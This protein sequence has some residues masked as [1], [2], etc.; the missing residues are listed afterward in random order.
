LP[1]LDLS[2]TPAAE[3]EAAVHRAAE[4]ESDRPFDLTRG[5]LMRALLIRESRDRHLL[6]L[7]VHHIVFDGFSTAV[8]LRDLSALYQ[9][10][11]SGRPADL[12]VLPVQ[13]VDYA[14]WQQEQLQGPGMRAR[15]DRW[16]SRLADASRV[17]DLPT[18]RPRPAVQSNRGEMIPV[19]L[20][21]A[22]AAEIRNLAGRE[23]ATLFMVLLAGYAS[24]LSR[25]T[26]QEDLNVG[27]FVANRPRAA[28]EGL[29][30][31]F[32]N[33]LVLR[34]DLAGDPSFRELLARVRETSLDAFE[35][36]EVP[37]ESLLDELEIGR[38]LSRN[39]LFQV[40]FGLQNF[41]M[42]TIETPGLR[43]RPVTL[44]QHSRTNAELAFWLA[45]EGGTLAGLLQLSTDL[46]DASTVLRMFGHLE[47]LLA[48][49][50]ADP[51]LRLSELPLMSAEE[52][53]QILVEW[54]RPGER[55]PAP[56]ALVHERFERWAAVRPDAV[57]LETADRSEVLTYAELNRRGNRLA[58]RLRRLGVG[59]DSIVGI[60]AERCV[61]HIVSILGVLKAGGAYMPL[62]PSLPEERLGAQIRS[63]GVSVILPLDSEPA[64]M[65]LSPDDD[66]D[67]QP[68]AVPE[69]LAYTFFTS[70]STGA[71][72]G[73]LIP[74][75][76]LANFAETA[77]RLY[78]IG[79]EDRVLQFSSLVFDI[80]VEE[81]FA[82]WAAG[83]TLV[84]RDEEMISSPARFLRACGELDVQMLDLPT[85]YWHELGIEL[86]KGEV[87][88]PACVRTVI[89]AGERALQERLAGWP[90]GVRLLNS[91]G[92][93]E[94]CPASSV[95][96][97]SETVAGASTN[98]LSIGRPMRGARLYVADFDHRPV[99]VGVAGELLIA[100]A[101][102]GR[103][104]AGQPDLTAERFIPDPFASVPGERAYRTGD[105][106]RWLRDGNLKFLGR[107]DHQ[108]KIRGFRIEPG[109]IAAVLCRYP[110]VREAVVVPRESVAAGTAVLQLV[111][112]A[113]AEPGIGVADLRKHV[114]SALPAYMVPADFVLLDALP[115][116]ATGKLDRRALPAPG[117]VGD[118]NYAAPETATEELLAGIWADLLGRERVGVFDDFF[119]LGGHSL[120]AP[121][122]LARIEE[123]FQ[124]E[125]PLRTLFEAPTVAQLATRIEEELLAQIEELSDEE[126]QSLMETL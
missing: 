105:R 28:L 18:D 87:G 53:S 99:P 44:T 33:T 83:S 114:K 75:G 76:A 51:G 68:L 92:P 72:K 1:L 110:G 41:A 69:S 122:V 107:V 94:A 64:G 121:Q 54:N 62:D 11:V 82:S 97:A 49:G 91:Y 96:D 34:V 101:G 48:A 79:S 26:G 5:P 67:P 123:T 77:R 120:L 113:A 109:E 9:A 74:H 32:V 71:P 42:P 52:T 10:E 24:L 37:F 2:A 90:R 84:L 118:D 21:P 117:A 38:D 55:E 17:L 39:P 59:L 20:P 14:A 29:I 111:A 86:A 80:S 40:L 3:R 23:G 95:F 65:P 106:V 108:V 35:N 8:L 57:A 6:A 81:I 89:F 19:A 58:H 46:F 112:Y 115:L 16:K 56:D 66:L 22:G 63:S 98:G 60:R 61:E 4:S 78:G 31:F 116:T 12:P 119:D 25:Y 100:G 13:Y 47:R 93:T 15:L 125:L 103:G 7:T 50:A 104:Y 36:Q 102:V 27:T 124:V 30:G 70:G 88:L 45:E 73:V 126:A 43:L 85:A